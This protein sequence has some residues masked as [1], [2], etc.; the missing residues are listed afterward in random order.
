MAT[1]LLRLGFWIL[2]LVLVLFVLS[3]EA[4]GQDWS[5]L[6]EMRMLGQALAL[7][8][9]LI[10]AGVVMKILGKGVAVVSKN[11]CKVCRTPVPSGAIY[12][13]AHL[14]DVLYA[15]DDRSHGTRVR[16]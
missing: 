3:S 5:H 12:C 11:R 13:R 10:V 14:R 4:A 1:T 16:K 15:E 7:G 8:V 2:I 6:I 9:L